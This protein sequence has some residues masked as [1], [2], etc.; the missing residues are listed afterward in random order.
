MELTEDVKAMILRR[1]T[2]SE[3]KAALVTRGFKTLRASS[4]EAVLAGETTLEEMWRVSTED[5][6]V[7]E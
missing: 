5:F 6:L 4:L 7:G 3:I 1:A 2:S